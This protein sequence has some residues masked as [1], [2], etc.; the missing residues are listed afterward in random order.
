MGNAE[1]VLSGLRQRAGDEQGKVKAAFRAGVD[2]YHAMEAEGLD[3]DRG[4]FQRRMLERFLTQP[5]PTS[6][7]D[8]DYLL[9]KIDRLTVDA[10]A[11]AARIMAAE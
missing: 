8:L 3:Q 1:R 9:D 5:H 4:L 2:A 7:D 10:P 11:P 6:K